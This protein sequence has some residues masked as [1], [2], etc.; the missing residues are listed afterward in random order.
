M[1]PRKGNALR[2]IY[3]YWNGGTW[4][5]DDEAVGLVRE[6]FVAGADTIISAA[7]SGIKNARKGFRLT[8]SSKAFPG[9]I[10]KLVRQEEEHGGYWYHN[11]DTGIRGWLC[12][13]TLCYFTKHPKEIHAAFDSLK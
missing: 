12:P 3:P 10:L 2:V 9:S 11:P 6:P 5:F 8:F 13:A 1:K 4:V 7:V